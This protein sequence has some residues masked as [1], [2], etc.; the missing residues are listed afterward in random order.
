MTGPSIIMAPII[1]FHWKDCSW[2]EKTR[3]AQSMFC[4]SMIKAFAWHFH[5]SKNHLSYLLVLTPY[6]CCFVSLFFESHWTV[7]NSVT[8]LGLWNHSIMLLQASVHTFEASRMFKRYQNILDLKTV[9]IKS[10]IGGSLSGSSKR[11]KGSH[12]NKPHTIQ[13][14]SHNSTTFL[15]QRPPC[16]DWK[17]F[18]LL[19]S[20]WLKAS[21]FYSSLTSSGEHWTM[22]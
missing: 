4:A 8:V 11:Y 18:S 14:T 15:H 5:L 17:P 2:P 20:V 6:H 13:H 12:P 16:H 22:M 7:P 1:Q 9:G 21:W 3:D 10:A 19:G